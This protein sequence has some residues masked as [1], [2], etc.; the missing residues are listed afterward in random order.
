MSSYAGFIR[1]NVLEIKLKERE[2]SG[3]LEENYSGSYHKT[4]KEKSR[5]EIVK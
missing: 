3:T 5:Q 2:T 1:K 4:K